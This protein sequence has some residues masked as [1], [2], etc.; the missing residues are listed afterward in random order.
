M[1]K[2]KGIKALEVLNE[3]PRKNWSIKDKIKK[4]GEEVQELTW[5]VS[6]NNKN[7]S[8]DEAGDCALLLL[9]IVY[10]IAGEDHSLDELALATAK[11]IRKRKT[12]NIK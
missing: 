3:T 6:R 8:L 5:D 2:K 11:K 9:S 12:T 4:L 1:I 7:K 10:D